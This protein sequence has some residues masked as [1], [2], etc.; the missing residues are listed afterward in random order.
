MAQPGSQKVG[1]SVTGHSTETLAFGPEKAEA[2][3]A[4][5]TRLG[6][7]EIVA[8]IGAGGMGVVYRA[9]DPRLDRLVAVKLLPAEQAADPVARERL[10][11]EALAA[12]A[13]DHPYICKIFEIGEHEGTLFLVMEYIA[14]ETLHRRMQSAR[15]PL[16][17]VFRVAEEIGEAL[18]EAHA[19]GFVHRDLKP[20][21]IMLTNQ[22]HV[23][24]MDF[25][26]ARRMEEAATPDG[27]TAA[28]DTQLSAP[29]A[30]NGTPDYMSP[31]QAR[32]LAL[33]GRSDQF[34]LGVILAEM[35][36]GQHPFRRRTIAETLT[37]VMRDAPD[38][39]TDVPE[40][41]A[42][43]ALVVM[44][45]RMLAKDP[46]DRYSSIGAMRADL[47]RLSAE[48][49]VVAPARVPPFGREAELA[50]L[51]KQLAEALAGRGSMVLIGGEPG[52]GKSHLT[53][54]LVDE[55]R[56]RGAAAVTGHC[57][58]MEGSAAYAP[59]V[60]M[61]EYTARV[62]PR[63]TFR[64]SLGEDA[65][66][67]AR[68]MPELR[69]IF[70]DIPAAMELPAEQQRRF[71]FNGYRNFVERNAQLTPAVLL[72]EDLHWADEPTLLLLQHLVQP[73]AGMPILIVG[74]YRDAEV[75]S[76]GPFARTLETLL[77]RKLA[78]RIGL[79]R[80]GVEGVG[81]MLAA[82]SSQPAPPSFVHMVFKE[83]EGN[84][85]F[86]EEVFRHL[87]E[88]G[89][90]FDPRG[91]FLGELKVD[92][93]QVPENVRLVLGRR[94]ERLS[95][96]SRRMLCTAAV[97]GRSFGLE[98]LEE[99]E[100]PPREAAGSAPDAV[101]ELIEEAER[102]RL[103]EAEPA[104]RQARY[105]F[106]HELVRQTL[107]ETLSLPRRQR[108]HAR[109]ADA[110]ERVHKNSL[111][112]HIPAL[113]HHLY[114]AGARVDQDRVLHFL[115]EAA[116]RAIASA[117]HE[118][119]LQHLDKALSLVENERTARA[120]ALH[121]RRAITLRSLSR[122]PEAFEEIE[123]ALG[124]Y[125]SL[126]D[127]A[128][129]SG[130][131]Y[132]LFELHSYAMQ[133]QAMNG[134][135][136]RAARLAVTAEER[137]M[138]LAMQAGC[139]SRFGESERALELVEEMQRVRGDELT[140]ALEEVVVRTH[141]GQYRLSGE[142][143][144]KLDRALEQAGNL[145]DR[146][147]VGFS[148]FTAP[149]Y[150]GRPAEAGKLIQEIIHLAERV[151]HDFAKAMALYSL[152]NQYAATGELN[153][154]ERTGREALNFAESTRFPIV[155][156][157]AAAV[158]GRIL[159]L[160][161]RMDE[162]LGLLAKSAGGPVNLMSGSAEGLLA[163]A[164]TAAG[165][166]GAADACREAERFLPRPGA[167]RGV[168]TWGAVMC[169]AQAYCLSGR[170]GE[171]AGLEADAGKIAREWDFS[172]VGI[173]AKTVAGITSAC[174]GN[175]MRAEE[176]HRAA[177]AGMDAAA[178]VTAQPMARYWYADMLAERGGRG[179]ADAAKA[180]LEQTIDASERIGL[181]LYARLARQRL[182]EVR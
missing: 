177:I 181:A 42:A 23:K 98:L 153:A 50:Q 139:A 143:G 62:A 155:K 82:L 144:Q 106:V 71:L 166:A 41:V 44:I 111:D 152:A 81:R 86:V 123:R 90:L 100:A 180:L 72:F 84:P 113:A 56:R 158:L 182:A 43:R 121:T 96:S 118:D 78:T 60:E 157:N 67:V 179:D 55:A 171:A 119:A 58:E 22:S 8:R 2:P 141:I 40:G 94:L 34:S 108:L 147:T 38:F 29:G 64:R 131:A 150:C 168:G 114:Q 26:L 49:E 68:L 145:W 133:L 89:K 32:G 130:T 161:D 107:V 35:A 4:P 104:G 77:R 109:I 11:R 10:R 27:E 148:L 74:T 36:A 48:Q 52:I 13:L 5:G 59:F 122:Q 3:V 45:R 73:V 21:N 149:L 128:G 103:V 70:P 88:E 20:A 117:A 87:A 146:A 170:R 125:E 116:R 172:L 163:L 142:A 57:H 24:V 127:H 99:L 91:A 61:L 136:A 164:L 95:E 31:E 134:V 39:G 33:D 102:L 54:A 15:Q 151:G 85:F 154:A 175:W 92:Q 110:L 66:E 47:A 174:A 25:G 167:S 105:R 120:A 6:R 46:A 178:Y 169:L 138:A 137:Y 160:S 1:E 83:T 159:T 16:A 165:L 7:Y 126:G 65:P 79:R 28:V 18:E 14:G 97:V 173:P 53:A 30:V 140:P 9:H 69:R 132:H 75:E 37:A 63:D 80:L 17:D 135:A 51:T 112:A 76:G 93:L 176:Y 12:A 19:R 101:L 156:M 115:S 129:F 162:A 124:L